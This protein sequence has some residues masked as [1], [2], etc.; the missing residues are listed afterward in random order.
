MFDLFADT[1]AI[2]KSIICYE[3]LSGQIFEKNSI[4]N[5]RRIAQKV[6]WFAWGL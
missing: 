2:L 5:R 3:M 6:H 1:T 4:Y